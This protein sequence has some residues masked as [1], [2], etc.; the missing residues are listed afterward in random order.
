MLHL[1]PLQIVGFFSLK[2]STASSVSFQYMA[3]L[4]LGPLLYE[5]GRLHYN[6]YSKKQLTSN[7]RVKWMTRQNGWGGLILKE[8]F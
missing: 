1:K 7:N 5:V 3:T 4:G 6:S 8:I 2:A